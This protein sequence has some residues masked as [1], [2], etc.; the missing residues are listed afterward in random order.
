MKPSLLMLRLLYNPV[1]IL[2]K[3]ENYKVTFGEK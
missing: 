2:D 1:L 3:S